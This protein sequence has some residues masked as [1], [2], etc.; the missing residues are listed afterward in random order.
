VLQNSNF[1]ENNG[2]A[3]LPPLEKVLAQCHENSRMVPKALTRARKAREKC[4]HLLRTL[5]VRLELPC[6]DGLEPESYS[7]P[8]Q[9]SHR[10]VC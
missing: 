6:G 10:A 1:E 2:A 5:Q 7:R 3:Q 4:D 9:G 8:P